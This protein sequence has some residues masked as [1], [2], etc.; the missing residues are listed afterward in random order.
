MLG[1]EVSVAT[2]DPLNP[3]IAEGRARI[4]TDTV[5]VKTFLDALNVK[6]G[7]DYD[8]DFLDPAKNAT[9]RVRPRWVFALDERDFTGSPTRWDL[10]SPAG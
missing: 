5:S 1:S 3:V 4:M 7:T 8:L 2:G 6:Y 10:H 9:V